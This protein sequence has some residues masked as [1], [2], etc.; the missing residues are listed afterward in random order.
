MKN[1]TFEGRKAFATGKIE[2]PYNPGTTNY[3]DWQFGF[4]RAYFENLERITGRGSQRV[5]GEQGQQ[6]T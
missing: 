4:D 2:N 6:T 3:R 1:A 5:Q